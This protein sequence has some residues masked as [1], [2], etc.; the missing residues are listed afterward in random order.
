[1]SEENFS[2]EEDVQ[3]SRGGQIS[4][5]AATRE[6]MKQLQNEGYILNNQSQDEEQENEIVETVEVDEQPDSFLS[7][8]LSTEDADV[9]N[10]AK[11][12]LEQAR[13]Y[14]MVLEHDIFSDVKSDPRATHKVQTEIK[15]FIM[16]RLEILLGMRQEKQKQ[17]SASLSQFNDM[18]ILALKDLAFKLTKGATASFSGQEQT[19]T[20][21]KP[22]GLKTLSQA[23]KTQLPVR[24]QKPVPRKPLEKSVK[25][26]SQEE[27]VARS[28]QVK[29]AKKAMPGVNKPIPMPD[30]D[31][32]SFSGGSGGISNGND[33]MSLIAR[34]LGATTIQ[35]VG[36]GA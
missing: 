11:V 30:G 20:P 15:N 8:L 27:L 36:D 23:M 9:L 24:Q 16:E 3:P 5:S 2:W 35:D 4:D 6:A 31:S 22:S 14:E 32:I 28:R 26:M 33:T 7:Q 10:T 25:D 29:S 13:L 18:E 17:Q 19:T 12:R 21:V 34:A 1:M